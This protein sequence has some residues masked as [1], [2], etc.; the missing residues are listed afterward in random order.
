MIIKFH[1]PKH[2]DFERCAS[3]KHFKLKE[4]Q[5][6]VNHIFNIQILK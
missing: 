3:N 6:S 4:K 2:G 5:I 1:K